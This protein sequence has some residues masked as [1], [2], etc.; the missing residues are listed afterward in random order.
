M[1]VNI[2]GSLSLVVIPQHPSEVTTIVLLYLVGL[3]LLGIVT[4]PLSGI[5]CLYCNVH[6]GQLGCMV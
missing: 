3:V 5:V 4:R 2:K 6:L 1:N